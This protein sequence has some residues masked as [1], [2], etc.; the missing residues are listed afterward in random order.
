MNIVEAFTGYD[1]LLSH[2]RSFEQNTQRIP[3]QGVGDQTGENLL[4]DYLLDPHAELGWYCPMPSLS[5]SMILLSEQSV[6]C[7][8]VQDHPLPKQNHTSKRR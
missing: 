1:I 6:W 4:P 7:H 8:Y 2:R 3:S 5:N